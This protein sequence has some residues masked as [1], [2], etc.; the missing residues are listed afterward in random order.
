MRISRVES[1]G[2][3]VSRF[4]WIILLVSLALLLTSFPVYGQ[5]T[6]ARS[7]GDLAQRLLGAPNPYALIDPA[8]AY[9]KGDSAQFW[10]PTVG[11]TKPA[12]VEATMVLPLAPGIAK[13]KG[14]FYFF[15]EDGIGVNEDALP[16]TDALLEGAWN[17]LR[18]NQ[19]LGRGGGIDPELPVPDVDSDPHLFILF[20]KNL[21]DPRDAFYNPLDSVP[22][23]LSPG[24][25]SNEHEIIYV[26]ASH[27]PGID[28][29]DPFYFPIVVRALYNLVVATYTP[30]QALWLR[31][32]LSQYFMTNILPKGIIDYFT[33]VTG[34]NASPQQIQQVIN[35]YL[36]RTGIGPAIPEASVFLTAPNANLLT[37]P[38]A[39][40][41]LSAALGGQQLFLNYLQ[42]RLGI[43]IF[44]QLFQQPG[45]GLSAVDA[46]LAR[47]DLVDATTEQRVTARDLY[48]DFVITNLINTT[49]GDRRFVHTSDLVDLSE[50]A[51]FAGAI[52]L[53]TVTQQVF[54][55][56][57]LSVN[58]FGA[59]YLAFGSQKPLAFTL[60]FNGNDTIDHLPMPADSPHANH[61][62]WSTRARNR[63]NT[64]TRAFDLRGKST[65]SL[66]F[67]TW[68]DL[69]PEWNYAYVTVS[70]DNGATWT[71]LPAT[72][73]STSNRYGAAYGAGFTGISTTESPRP[74]PYLGIT[75]KPD[76]EITRVLPDSPAEQGGLQEGDQI[77]GIDQQENPQFNLASTLAASQTGETLNLY[78]LRGKRRFSVPV[79]VGAHPTETIPPTARWLHET[80]DLSAFAGKQILVRFEYVSLPD[81]PNDGIAIDNI[82]L[83]EVGYADNAENETSDWTLNGWQRIDNNLPQRFTVQVITA[84]AGQGTTDVQPLI[85]PN[86]DATTGQWNFSV[87]S[88]T[89]L[90]LAVSGLNDETTVPA[91]FSLA[92]GI[93]QPSP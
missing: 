64:L 21:N 75:V 33:A 58:Q 51:G 91:G 92:V 78:I 62:Y 42:Q 44:Q 28:V 87:D 7:P 10:V 53:S 31:A 27:F 40:E 12:R 73:T 49:F 1:D 80:V 47:S 48:A 68:Y 6:N 52:D 85:M 86:E 24:K 46:V 93:G 41:D 35:N 60:V 88:N 69:T 81:Q 3:M 76:G 32:S 8:P 26:N 67:D 16:L 45:E 74:A 39:L 63:D 83:P 82:A 14:S 84:Q 65:A 23:E 61:F 90:V 4:R 20:V 15:V 59:Y 89:L 37:Y 30:D 71:I 66:T 5:D 50:R 17:V 54:R 25:Y 22:A 9:K 18:S 13:G 19:M 79:V 36:D 72:N 77:I 29:G 34:S 55:L 43:N 11:S 2:S 57:S 70:S 38:P 56:D